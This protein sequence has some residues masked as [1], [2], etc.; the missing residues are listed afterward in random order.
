MGDDDDMNHRDTTSKRGVRRVDDLHGP[1]GREGL[2]RYV[3]ELG[4]YAYCATG[5]RYP[6]DPSQDVGYMV[7][8]LAPHFR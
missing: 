8:R 3:H 5:G 1:E 6:L 7:V 2:T 4:S